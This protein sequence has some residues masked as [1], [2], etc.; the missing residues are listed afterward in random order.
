MLT[1]PAPL[2]YLFMVVEGPTYT[3]GEF[4]P[5]LRLLSRRFA[6]ELWSYGSYEANL[7]FGSFRLRVVRDRSPYQ[8]FRNYLRFR[9]AVLARARELRRSAPPTI[10]VT[11]YDPFKGGLLALRVANILNCSFMC[12]VNGVYGNPDNLA[13]IASRLWRNVRLLQMRWLGS[14]VLSRANS[15]RLLFAA[16]L[17]G[18]VRLPSR[19]IVRQFFALSFTERFF[20]AAGEKLILSAGFPF[21]SKGHDVL[22]RAFMQIAPRFPEWRLLLIG[23]LVPAELRVRGLLHPQIEAL[24]G[25]P[26]PQLAEWM[27]RCEIFALASRSEAMGRVLLEAAAAGKCRVATRVGGIPTVVADGRDGVLVQ[28]DNVEELSCALERLIQDKELRRRL[29]A[30]AKVRVAQ[31]FS[32]DVY[33]CHF[34]ELISSTLAA[35]RSRN[36]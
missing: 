6:G 10:V 27:S 17:D 15:V 22:V 34:E 11:S 36:A 21:I 3:P 2:A 5:T 35:Q 16:Q 29:G 28:K 1:T 7:E 33:L 9:R 26:Q 24:P 13:Y 8:R 19:V 30:A 18:F 31:D 14:F 32:P 12:E 4:E 23:H 20:E 25:M